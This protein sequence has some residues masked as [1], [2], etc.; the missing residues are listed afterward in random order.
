MICYNCLKHF[1]VKRS[2]LTLF[3]TKKYYIC[4]SC[5]KA[6]PIHLQTECL[7]LENYELSIVTIFDHFF[8]LNLESY[9][10]ELSKIVSYFIKNKSE[11]F[12]VFLEKVVLND[13]MLETISFLADA[14]KKSILL[15]CCE[16]KK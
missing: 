1:Y 15:L 11:L 7:P 5:R 8:Q 13:I 16:L 3:E 12:L 2:F 4:D 10:L 6:Y 14:E 9:C